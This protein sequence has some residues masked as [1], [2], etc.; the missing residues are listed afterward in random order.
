MD[1]RQKKWCGRTIRAVKLIYITMPAKIGLR[2]R[3]VTVAATLLFAFIFFGCGGGGG[4]GG[5]SNGSTSGSVGNPT[6]IAAVA[7]FQGTQA[8]ASPF[9]SGTSSTYQ[10]S[11]GDVV[12]IE[13]I[14]VNSITAAPQQVAA[15]NFSTN[16]PSS[17][18]T[19]SSTGLL[20]AVASSP[21]IQYTFSAVYSGTTYTAPFLVGPVSPKVAGSVRDTSNNPVAGVILNFY[22]SSGTLLSQSISGGDGSFIGNVTTSAA[23]F[24]ADASAITNPGYFK[25]YGYN[26]LYY[27]TASTNCYSPLPALTV[28]TKTTLPYQVVVLPSNDPADPPP[29]PTGCGA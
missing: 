17:V 8:P 14:G 29:P 19:I 3:V 4:G 6:N 20:T 9:T 18:A 25:E 1:F 5:S 7:L 28:G 22:N 13:L 23:E 2:E 24:S 27:S 11:Q 12:Q 16:A 21:G 10:L 26:S 15:T